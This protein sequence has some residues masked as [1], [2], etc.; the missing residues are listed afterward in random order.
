[1]P[2]KFVSSVSFLTIALVLAAFN[3]GMAQKSASDRISIRKEFRGGTESTVHPNQVIAEWSMTVSGE[4]NKRS[5]VYLGRTGDN[6]ID[7]ETREQDITVKTQST[8]EAAIHKIP[9][10]LECD[11]ETICKVEDFTIVMRL[12]GNNLTY[13]IAS[14]WNTDYI[15]LKERVRQCKSGHKWIEK[16]YNYC[17]ACGAPLR[18]VKELSVDI[19]DQHR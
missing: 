15:S 2:N 13:T 5:L 4:T 12:S 1:M 6:T 10:Y 11:G 9:L 17:P 7:L 3:C 19:S 14:D 16:E 18:I 8:K